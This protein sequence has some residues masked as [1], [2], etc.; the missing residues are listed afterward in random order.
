[1]YDNKW[2]M[3]ANRCKNIYLT[4]NTFSNDKFSYLAIS[5]LLLTILILIQEKK[6]FYLHMI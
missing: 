4:K 3:Q 2:K 6:S 5:S 1:M